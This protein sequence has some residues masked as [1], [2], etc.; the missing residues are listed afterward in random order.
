MRNMSFS[1]TTPQM[2][3]REKTVTRRLG[4]DF[5]NVGDIV[6]AVEK[7]QG[8]KKGEKVVKISAI[9]IVKINAE[10]VNEITPE[11]IIKEG[12]PEMGVGEFVQMFCKANNCNPNTLINR[13]EFSFPDINGFFGMAHTC[14]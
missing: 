12:F 3:A 9:K 14:V 8:L 13:I 1:L 4:W 11:E 6:M 2:Y 5:L 7:C 10:M